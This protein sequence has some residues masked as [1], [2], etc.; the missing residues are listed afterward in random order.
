MRESR[1]WVLHMLSALVILVF[2]GLH[3]ALMHLSGILSLV[4][5]VLAKP[6]AWDHVL[7]RARS[8]FFTVT[9]VFML[10]AALF[11]GLYGLRTMIYEVTENPALR[12]AVTVTFVAGGFGLFGLGTFALIAMHLMTRS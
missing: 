11:H 12:K 8:D 3:M 10:A 2:L 7:A 5:P 9:Y 1:Y 6:V 4:D